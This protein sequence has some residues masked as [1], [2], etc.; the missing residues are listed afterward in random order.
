MDTN[1]NI[2]SIHYSCN[3]FYKGG[4]I[5]PTI[6]CIAMYN[7]KTEELK[8]FSLLDGI[9][10]G[11]SI[12]ESEQMLLQSFTEFF[13]SIENPF[14]IHWRMDD[15]EYGFKA[16]MGRCGNF[17]IQNIDWNKMTD[18]NLS[19]FSP[20][21]LITTLED[22]KCQKVTLLSGKDE[23]TCFDKRDYNLVKLS[24][25]A[26]AYGIAKVFRDYI[27]G[28]FYYDNNFDNNYRIVNFKEAL[29]TYKVD[30]TMV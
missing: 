23:A 7:V 26:K 16:I 11:K 2:Y 9:I 29:H 22:H 5:A 20:C 27:N 8:S 17:G 12:I 3:G 18:F 13:N 25:E 30:K 15:L 6:C 4:A 1:Y 24:T 21:G 14:I 10:Q 28:F 19:E